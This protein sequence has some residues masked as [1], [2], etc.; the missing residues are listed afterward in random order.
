[1][2]P[3]VGRAVRTTWRNLLV[4][5]GLVVGTTALVGVGA[6][7]FGLHWIRH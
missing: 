5:M 6:L 4:E 7:A 3:H 1:M 2:G